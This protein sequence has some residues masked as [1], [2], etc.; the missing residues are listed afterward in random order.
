MIKKDQ[1]ATHRL[2]RLHAAGCRPSF[3]GMRFAFLRGVFL[4]L[5]L[6]AFP[7][8]AQDAPQA[9]VQVPGSAPTGSVASP[10]SAHAA[11]PGSDVLSYWYGPYYRTPF[12]TRTGSGQAA[13]IPRNALEYTHVGFWGMGSNF[14]DLM[15]SKSNM[16]EPAS[17]GGSGA[18]EAYFI[19]RS[20]IGLN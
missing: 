15:L 11:P 20:N 13:D 8:A 12:V 18:V 1:I 5:P 16:A 2:T 14:G 7:L 19:W 9:A 6:I 3:A 10:H 17:G 4:A